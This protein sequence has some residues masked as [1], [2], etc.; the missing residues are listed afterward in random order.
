MGRSKGEE[1]RER[2]GRGGGGEGEKRRKGGNEERKEGKKRRKGG[3]EENKGKGIQEKGKSPPFP[4]SSFSPFSSLTSLP[5]CDLTLV[6]AQIT[7]K[8]NVTV[9]LKA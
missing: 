9:T 3:L 8:K 1:R 4:L 7:V 6:S 5:P 2:E